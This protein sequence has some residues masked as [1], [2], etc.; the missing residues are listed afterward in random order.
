MTGL[1]L[2]FTILGEA[3]STEITRQE[4]A[5]GFSENQTTARKGGRI[6]GNARREL[7]AETGKPFVSET[8]YLEKPQSI[9]DQ[10]CA[11]E[12]SDDNSPFK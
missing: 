6:A 5:Q 9:Q 2:A 10:L 8:N 4:N 11:G 1:E 3:A 12:E 7:E